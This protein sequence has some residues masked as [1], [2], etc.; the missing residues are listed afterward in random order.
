MNIWRPVL[1]DDLAARGWE[2]VNA[3]A[4]DL[5]A[6]T[7]GEIAIVG[8]PLASNFSLGSGAA[9]MALFYGYLARAKAPGA[10]GHATRSD[11]LLEEAVQ[12]V[13][14]TSMSPSLYGGFTGVAWAAEHLYQ[15]SR[16][17][18][19]IID[20]GDEDMD[21]DIEEGLLM[22]L[23]KPWTGDYDLIN[24][25][26]GIGVYA[27]ERI[28]RPSAVRCLE[29]IV[30]KLADAA[31]WHGDAV[32]WF[33]PPEMLTSAM[34]EES[35]DGYYNLGVAHGIP[36][37]IA[38]L[39]Q[40]YASGIRDERALA[41][42]KGAVRWVVSQRLTETVG[43][44]FPAWV[45]RGTKGN[46]SRFAWCYGDPG[47]A[48]TLL[49]AA[50]ATGFEEWE[51]T[52]LEIAAR[53]ASAPM[54]AARVVDAGLC[55]G[56]LGLAHLYNRIYQAGGGELFAD[57]A[58]RWFLT[59]LEMR[60]AVGIGGFEAWH[61]DKDENF[62]WMPDPGFLTGVS[63]IGLAFLAGLTSCVPNWDRV[64]LAAVPD[65]ARGVVAAGHPTAK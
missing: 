3:I 32:A 62:R 4:A 20:D 13:A 11:N 14:E 44:C 9:G 2:A 8:N 37:V 26:V 19:A 40:V 45:K 24:G 65:R 41:M 12:A 36:G 38:L 15:L 42:L 64:L 16:E 10:E 51:R 58:R 34:L 60:K 5:A 56:A 18:V 57:A 54:E 29:A 27:L 23:S 6:L 63:G 46:S 28:P 48:V 21:E 49:I 33:T 22:A 25:L 50:R 17:N 53:A 47:V 7:T 39:A 52:A 31:E 55:H 61:V 35:P 1:G 30:D 43:S 59:G